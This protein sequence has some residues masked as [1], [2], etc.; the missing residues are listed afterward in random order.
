MTTKRGDVLGHDVLW[1]RLDMDAYDIDPRT[2]VT[3][4][5]T[6]FWATEEELAGELASAGLKVIHQ[7]LRDEDDQPNAGMMLVSVLQ[8]S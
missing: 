4:S 2:R 3:R 7:E 6:R 1:P 5:R 8:R